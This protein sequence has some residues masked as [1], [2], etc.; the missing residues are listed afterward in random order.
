MNEVE[1]RRRRGRHWRS[2]DSDQVGDTV[3]REERAFSRLAVGPGGDNANAGN[4]W[5]QLVGLPI[6]I[7]KER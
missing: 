5:C 3:C 7:H 1:V 4:G 6:A 2:P